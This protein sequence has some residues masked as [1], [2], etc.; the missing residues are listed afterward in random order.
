MKRSIRY[1]AYILLGLL[2]VSA[3]FLFG[4]IEVSDIVNF[5]PNNPWLAALV[6]LALFC[7]KT[8]VMVIPLVVLYISAGIMFPAGWAFAICFVGLF[9]EMTIGYHIGKRLSFERVNGLTSRYKR[10]ENLIP[11]EGG[12][13]L[14]MGFLLRMTPL[15]FDIVS[16]IKGA[17]GMKYK[18]YVLITY[19]GTLLSIIPY[20]YIGRYITTPLSMEFIIPLI[21]IVLLM[22]C[23]FIISKI[24]TDHFSK[25]NEP[26]C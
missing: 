26:D 8:V 24:R 23:P 16:M 3:F 19:A 22:V 2:I 5:T 13:S 12:V 4:N 7:I 14:P 20:I 21:L 15:P 17:F 10:L 18:S 6:M 11:E 25:D 9:L 1:G